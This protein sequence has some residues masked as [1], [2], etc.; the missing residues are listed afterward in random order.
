VWV[1]TC[2]RP[3]SLRYGAAGD[4]PKALACKLSALPACVWARGMIAYKVEKDS[5][6]IVSV[7]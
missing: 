1:H 5:N 2:N 7:G 4:H 3:P 6:D